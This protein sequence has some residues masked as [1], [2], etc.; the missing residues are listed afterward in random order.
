[1]ETTLKIFLPYEKT[2]YLIAKLG[3]EK[4]KIISKGE[5]STEIEI[6]I[7]SGLDLIDIFYS[8]VYAGMD[9]MKKSIR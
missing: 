3:E 8:G 2:T 6:K 4:A 7:S 1:M 5:F 9:V